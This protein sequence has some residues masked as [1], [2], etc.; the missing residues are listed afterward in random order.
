MAKV[1]K[2]TGVSVKGRLM[3]K[4]LTVGADSTPE[5]AKLNA[6]IRRML[7]KVS[8][9]GH[10]TVNEMKVIGLKPPKQTNSPTGKK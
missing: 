8:N 10:L 7:D 4:L 2:S 6:D 3:S 1:D 5:G 9:K